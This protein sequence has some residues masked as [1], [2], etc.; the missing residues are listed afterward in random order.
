LK[1]STGKGYPG[2]SPE[3]V[4]VMCHAIRSYYEKTGEKIGLKVAGGISTVDDAVKY[5]TLVKEMLG[6]EWCNPT[7][8]RI[9]ASRLAD[10]LLAEIENG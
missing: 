2:A 5:Y 4:Y 7:L 9:G 6:E 10:V 8:F 1:T 3:A